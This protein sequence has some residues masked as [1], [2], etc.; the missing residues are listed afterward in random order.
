MRLVLSFTA[1][2]AALGCSPAATRLAPLPVLPFVLDSARVQVVARGVTHRFL[3]S[4]EGPWAIHL[5]DVALDRCI[6]ARAVKGFPGPVGRERTSTLL[7]RL[8]DS[9]TVL[10]GVNADFFS[11]DPPGVPVG[12]MVIDG[13]VITG[14]SRWPVLAID[15]AGRARVAVLSTGADSLT[16][17]TGL[18]PFHPLQAVGGRPELLRDGVLTAAAR[19]TV[20]FAV[21]R[22]PRTA[23]GITAD[24]RLLLLTVDGRQPAWSVGMRLD[25]LATLLLALGA[26]DAINLDGGG[27][28]AMVVRD[29]S[30]GGLALINRP[31]DRE[32]ERAVG[33]ALAVVR[34]C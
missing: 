13:V 26:V 14:P 24:G 25:E 16:G 27:S 28:T 11:F 17:S 10:G 30:G 1:L 8:A 19:D 18:R 5:L 34:R 23:A 22:H 15:S 12:A 4:S 7:D 31:S 2:V 29:P 9:V 20:A 33:N 3:H 32:G 6:T 21:T